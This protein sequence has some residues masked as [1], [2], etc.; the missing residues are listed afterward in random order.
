[1]AKSFAIRHDVPSRIMALCGTC[2][3]SN[4]HLIQCAVDVEGVHEEMELSYS[5]HYEIIQ[6]QG[7]ENHSF[8]KVTD[9]EAE[10]RTEVLYPP[11]LEGRS[12]LRELWWSSLAIHGIY[13]ETHGALCNG[14]KTL[15]AIGI[16][17]IIEA[18]CKDRKAP[19][20]DLLSRI[21]GLFALGLLSKQDAA[22]I[23]RLRVMGNAAAH[24]VAPQ[25]A[26][27]LAIAFDVV[28]HLLR[29]LYLLPRRARMIGR[30][31]N[32]A[33]GERVESP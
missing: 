16:R 18:I 28:E 23:Q 2:Q 12:P 19:G 25:E 7:C 15:A 17:T 5:E 13:H 6:C 27:E 20:S 26:D 9:G 31:D 10:G 33:A 11:R 4:V 1:M 30:K 24:E 14:F 22:I 21:D 8:R 32:D 29:G 3:R